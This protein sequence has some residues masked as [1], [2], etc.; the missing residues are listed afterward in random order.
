[1]SLKNPQYLIQPS[2]L[3]FELGAVD[4]RIL[5]CTVFLRRPGD[6]AR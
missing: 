5:D 1:M 6:G 2:A 4:L 3:K